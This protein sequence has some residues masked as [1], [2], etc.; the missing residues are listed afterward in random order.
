MSIEV[1]HK[2]TKTNVCMCVCF[3]RRRFGKYKENLQRITA[4]FTRQASS[5]LLLLV[6]WYTKA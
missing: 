5:D 1:P 6:N 3:D 4:V 2:N